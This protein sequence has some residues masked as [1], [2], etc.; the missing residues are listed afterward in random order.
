MGRVRALAGFVK[1]RGGMRSDWQNGPLAREMETE[2]EVVVL[3]SFSVILARMFLLL[4]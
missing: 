4:L 1:G 3:L 2:E